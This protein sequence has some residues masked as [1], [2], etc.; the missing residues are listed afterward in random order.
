MISCGAVFAV[1]PAHAEAPPSGEVT[2]PWA[3]TQLVPGPG[4]LHDD[5]GTH[6]ALRWQVTPVLYAFR[7]P[8]PAPRLRAFVVDPL[9]RVSGSVELAVVPTY[10]RFSAGDEFGVA[11][12]GRVTLPLIEKGEA[13]AVWA[14]AGALTA[15]GVVGPVYEGGISTLFGIFGI[16]VAHAPRHAGGTT[17]VGLRFRYF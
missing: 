10:L 16:D 12:T 6:L 9:A 7:L 3:L 15:G 14:G 2:L 5:G 8:K 4:A 13:F 11:T 1:T 17:L